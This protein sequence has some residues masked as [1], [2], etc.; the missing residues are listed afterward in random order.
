MTPVAAPYSNELRAQGTFPSVNRSEDCLVIFIADDKEE[1]R[2]LDE[3]LLGSEGMYPGAI[4]EGCNDG[5]SSFVW[6][7][8]MLNVVSR[9]R[10]NILVG[11]LGR[12]GCIK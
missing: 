1:G 6:E 7:E 8:D 3:E 2:I 12:S 11:G 4:R 10:W 5:S 9:L